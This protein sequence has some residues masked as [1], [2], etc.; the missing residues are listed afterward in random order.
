MKPLR[1]FTLIE[2]LV[3][4]AIIAIIASILFPVLSRAKQ[5]G[6]K[7]KSI[8]NIM[9]FGHATQLYCS[10][11]D[12][13][14]PRSDYCSPLDS[15]NPDLNKEGAV[16]GDGCSQYP[17]PYRIN[18]YK[19]QKWLMPYATT[20]HL[21]DHPVMEKDRKMWEENG[22]IFDMYA[23]NLALTGAL[24][25][26]GNSNKN[27]AYRDS[28]LGGSPTN[29]PN[30]SEAML[31]MEFASSKINFVPIFL[32]PNDKYTTAYPTALRELWAPMFMKWKNK[33]DC[34][35][36]NEVDDKVVPF[37]GGIIIGK[38]DGSAKWMQVQVF[39]QR[40]PTK[41]DYNV[42]SY[43]GGWECGPTDGARTVSEKPQWSEE[44]PLW[45][46]D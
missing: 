31:F 15:L 27:G 38:V 44:W 5:A 34:T 10:N 11:W 7:T 3:V 29:V 33:N 22:E 4:I 8:S 26:W 24:N 30:P 19:W 35:P 25:T 18:H 23:I 42:G 9:Q 46:L 28:F 14:Y 37:S 32:Y 41:M 16:N 13:Q 2:M 1:A 17:F 20:I 6:K 21:F 12:D 40:T 36:T 39:L 45:A 43:A